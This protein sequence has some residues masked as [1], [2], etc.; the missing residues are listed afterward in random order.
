MTDSSAGDITTLT[1]LQAI[2]D[3]QRAFDRATGWARVNLLTPWQTLCTTHPQDVVDAAYA[4]EVSY[5]NLEYAACACP[6]K[7]DLCL[8]KGAPTR[9]TDK[10]L[11]RLHAQAAEA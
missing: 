2:H 8:L 6:T 1:L 9:L 7:C 3:H 4:R 5:G 10:G 11:A